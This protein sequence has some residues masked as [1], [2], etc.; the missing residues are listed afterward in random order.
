MSKVSQW[1]HVNTSVMAFASKRLNAQSIQSG[2]KQRA[3]AS[4]L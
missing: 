1:L 3:S 2:V 4:I